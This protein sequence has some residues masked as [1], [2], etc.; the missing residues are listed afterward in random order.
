MN[1]NEK[2][3]F[4]F[5]WYESEEGETFQINHYVEIKENGTDIEKVGVLMDEYYAK[6]FEG[7]DGVYLDDYLNL[8]KSNGFCVNYIKKINIPTKYE[9]IDVEF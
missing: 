1:N 9:I 5:Y 6:V 4:N 7:D 3:Y 2:Y 8:L